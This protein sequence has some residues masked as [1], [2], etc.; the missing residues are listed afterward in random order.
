MPSRL[1]IVYPELPDTHRQLKALLGRLRS[2]GSLFGLAPMLEE[3]HGLLISHFAHEQY[4]G[5]LYDILQ[6]CESVD[7]IEIETLVREHCALVSA[8]SG[9]VEQVRVARPEHEARLLR[10]LQDTV[11]RLYAHEEKEHRL[12]EPLTRKLGAVQRFPE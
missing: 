1:H 6:A 3:L 9:L 10:D 2:H 4:P 12:I 5:G 11:T 7:R 8:V